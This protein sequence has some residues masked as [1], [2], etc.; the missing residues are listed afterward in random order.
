MCNPHL[1]SSTTDYLGYYNTGNATNFLSSSGAVYIF[2]KKS[3]EANFTET[4]VQG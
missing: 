3:T 2:E 4:Q 1:Q